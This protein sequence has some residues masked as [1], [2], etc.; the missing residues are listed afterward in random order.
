MGAIDFSGWVQPL[1]PTGLAALCALV[2]A[3]LAFALGWTW[4][5]RRAQP[6]RDL[7]LASYR[8]APMAP[9]TEDQ[10]ALL[11]YLQSAFPD[12]AV[13]FR[14]RLARFLAVRA[15]LDRGAARRALEGMRVDYLLCGEDGKPLYAFEV[16][17][18]RQQAD[19][20][21]QR[22]LAEKNRMLKSAGIRLIRFK[23]ALANW[24]APQMLRERVLAAA[25][26]T[27]TP[28]GFSAS[29]LSPSSFGESGFQA[30]GFGASS[31]FASTRL[32]RVSTP[33]SGVMSLSD[34]AG[35][36]PANEGDAW[37]GVRK[38]S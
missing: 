22:S 14:P 1:G 10:I 15:G 21:L 29:G 34:L 18:L 38:R 13:L 25:R 3:G 5:R 20:Q 37:S 28:S 24:P 33:A 12:G 30:S 11:R 9:I 36:T 23:G 16:D 6:R 26:P 35:L 27:P 2:A 8:F 19:A 31:S 4:G 17:M 32:D 7:D